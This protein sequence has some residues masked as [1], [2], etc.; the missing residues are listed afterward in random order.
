MSG[1]ILAIGDIHGCDVALEVLLSSLTISQGDTVVVLGDVIDRGPNTRRCIELLLRL[2]ETCRLV[3]IQGNH[4]EM[5]FDALQEGEHLLQAW[6][7]FGGHETLQSYGG[8]VDQIPV[9]HFR[10]L[11]MAVPYWESDTHIF[12]HASLEPNK[13]LD[14]QTS[15]W[16]RWTRV[17]GDEPPHPSG[18]T[19][20]CGHSAQENGFPLAWNGWI[21]IDTWAY[22]GGWLTCLNLN[23]GTFVQSHQSGMFRT[24]FS[25]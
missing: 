12:I 4:E 3:L 8:R 22:G 20:V 21:C 18:K 15:H 11:E 6:L 10:F 25:I 17:A 13:E 23:T 7:G 2:R 1:R 9:E 14:R 19:V 24:G 16:L 5:L